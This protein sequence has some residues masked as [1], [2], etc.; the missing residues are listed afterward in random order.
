MQPPQTLPRLLDPAGFDGR[1]MAPSAREMAR[2]S[3]FDIIAVAL[4]AV[5]E[6]VARARSGRR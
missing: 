5:E 6:P 1:E 3:L 4:A 2:L